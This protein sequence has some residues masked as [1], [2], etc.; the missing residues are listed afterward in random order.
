MQELTARLT[1]LDPDAGAAVRVISYFDSLLQAHAGPSTIV[2]GAAVLAG[3]PARLVDDTRHVSVRMAPDGTPAPT[4]SS[5][6]PA[7]PHALVFR[8]ASA[9]LWLE[10]CGASTSIDTMILERASAAAAATMERTRSQVVP[11]GDDPASFELLVDETVTAYDRLRAA[12]RLGIRPEARLR[13]VALHGG[14]CL[15]MEATGTPQGGRAGIGPPGPLLALPSSWA[16]ARTALR[17]TAAGTDTDPGP[18]V[19]KADDLGGLAALAALASPDT[20]PTA[21]VQALTSAATSIP[22]LL[23]TLDAVAEASSLRTA[24]AALRVHHSTLQ[25]R[26]VAAERALGWQIREPQGRL[27]L[28]LALVLR[29]LHNSPR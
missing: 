28:Q 15:V 11:S 20:E 22:R 29:R 1:A 5:P 3:C 19:V 9:V 26:V 17:F 25:Q 23:V 6:D 24:A 18:R 16:A 2:R 14:A 27:R 4:A 7:W 13:A 10:R 8:D 21:D 12:H